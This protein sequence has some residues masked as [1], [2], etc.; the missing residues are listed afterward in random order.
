[1]PPLSEAERAALRRHLQY[2]GFLLVD[3]ADGSD[4]S[5]FDA[6]VRRELARVL[7]RPRRSCRSPATTSST[8]ASTC[9]TARAAGSS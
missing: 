8:R 4:G 5:G 6:S 3:A 1:M 7:P 9:S 2:G